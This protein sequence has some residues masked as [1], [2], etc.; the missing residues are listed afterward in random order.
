MRIEPLISASNGTGSGFSV[1]RVEAASPVQPVRSTTTAAA[2]E[3]SDIAPPDAITFPSRSREE[4]EAAVRAI[5]EAV[6]ESNIALKFSRDDDT[7]SIVIEMIDQN[8]G[9]PV[10]QIPSEASLKLSA[11][12]GKLQGNIV[13]HQA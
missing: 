8:T 11:A 9:E 12:L 10:R 1:S 13:N 3:Q 7:G 2:N 6:S 5:S 4:V